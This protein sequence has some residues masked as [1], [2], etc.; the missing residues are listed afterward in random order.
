MW[1]PYK[2]GYLKQSTL[3]CG[4]SSIHSF[5]LTVNRPENNQADIHPMVN[6]ENMHVLSAQVLIKRQFDVIGD[7]ISDILGQMECFNTKSL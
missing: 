2:S 6:K 5:F 3:F 7:L 1:R 4:T